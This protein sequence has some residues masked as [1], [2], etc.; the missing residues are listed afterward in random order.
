MHQKLEGARIALRQVREDVR[1]VIDKAYKD[2]EL[3]EDEKFSLQ[4]ELER[5]VRDQNENVKRIGEE[6]ETEIQTI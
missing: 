3:A 5:M 4:D 2:K 6:K 1:A